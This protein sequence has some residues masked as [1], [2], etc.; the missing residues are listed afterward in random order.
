MGRLFCWVLVATF[1]FCSYKNGLFFAVLNGNLPQPGAECELCGPKN[2]N[3][4]FSH[5]KEEL[6]KPVDAVIGYSFKDRLPAVSAF[7]AALKSGS[8]VPI[9]NHSKAKIIQNSK[10]SLH[11]CIYRVVNLEILSG[12][13]AGRKGWVL[14][15]DVIDNPLQKFLQESFRTGKGN[16]E[17]E[18]KVNE[19]MQQL[20]RGD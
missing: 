13:L 14:R 4:Y 1:L 17:K 7:A 9:A 10:F 3:A 16:L 18:L 20:F 12:P 11:G 15:D 5:S 8:I 6:R 19:K 2:G